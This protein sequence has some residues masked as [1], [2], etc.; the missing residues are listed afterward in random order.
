SGM[1]RRSTSRWYLEPS[2][3][4]STG[5]GPVAAPPFR[6]DAEAVDARARPVDGP[7][8]AQPVENLA[9]Q[10]R[11]DAGRLPVLQP[12]PASGTAPAPEFLGEQAPGRARA[13]DE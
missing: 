9:V 5:F 6:A 4:R 12:A 11:P 7:L 1:P 3:P 13:E 2:L 8:L 10:R